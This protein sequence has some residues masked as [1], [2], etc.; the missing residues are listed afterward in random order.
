MPID[1][2]Q[3]EN[4][5]NVAGDYQFTDFESSKNEYVCLR[6]SRFAAVCA[7]D[8]ALISSI[9]QFIP[10]ED[11][12]NSMSVLSS[13]GN[14]PL[15]KF[16]DAVK[17]DEKCY[18]LDWESAAEFMQQS[19]DVLSSMIQRNSFDM[20]SPALHN[21]PNTPQQMMDGLNAVMSVIDTFNLQTKPS[22]M[23]CGSHPTD[24]TYL[25]S[26]VAKDA[27][28]AGM[29]MMSRGNNYHHYHYN[30]GDGHK[31][32]HGHGHENGRGDASGHS[33]SPAPIISPSPAP[34]GGPDFYYLPPPAP[35][36]I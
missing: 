24:V 26:S 18:V 12:A 4:Y 22:L 6:P 9:S 7:N 36:S 17:D 33:P 16:E 32:G 10:P 1:I 8:A 35:N 29:S 21:A 31:H 25:L 27:M 14:L 15:F 11:G 13:G 2:V 5:R 20:N 30:D 23:I 28:L 3:V 34:N 19:Q